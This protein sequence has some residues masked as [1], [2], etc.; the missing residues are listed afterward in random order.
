MK[1]YSNP[2]I[3]KDGIGGSNEDLIVGLLTLDKIDIIITQSLLTCFVDGQEE[4][5]PEPKHPV[6][7][8]DFSSLSRLSNVQF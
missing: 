5:S 2:K 4:F 6:D 8:P 7:R 3:K 1:L